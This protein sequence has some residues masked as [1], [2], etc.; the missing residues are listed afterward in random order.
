[1]ML[2]PLL[3]VSDALAAAEALRK[4]KSTGKIMA[5]RLGDQ[6]AGGASTMDRPCTRKHPGSH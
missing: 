4:S 2:P 6:V 3:S 5:G 1:V